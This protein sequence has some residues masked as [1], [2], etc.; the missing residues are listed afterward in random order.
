MTVMLLYAQS[1]NVILTTTLYGRLAAFVMFNTNQIFV[2][3][4]PGLK[5]AGWLL[6]IS[7]LGE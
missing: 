7:G 5:M 6:V 1:Y 4:S 2:R 3:P